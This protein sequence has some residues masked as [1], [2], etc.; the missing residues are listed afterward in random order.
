MEAVDGHWISNTKRTRKNEKRSSRIEQA[1]NF[2]SHQRVDTIFEAIKK[3][4][5]ILHTQCNGANCVEMQN[6]VVGIW[7]VGNKLFQFELTLAWNFRS[8]SAYCAL[9]VQIRWA[10]MASASGQ[11]I[12]QFFFQRCSVS[13]LSFNLKKEEEEEEK[14]EATP[15][16]VFAKIYCCAFVDTTN[17]TRWWKNL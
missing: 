2:N 10:S 7:F 8:A 5:F 4:L 6:A 17:T 1:Y 14:K 11:G 12:F 13:H 16:I 3:T 15:W 9:L